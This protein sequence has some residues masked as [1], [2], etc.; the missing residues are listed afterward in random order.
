MHD[1]HTDKE[2][3][4]KYQFLNSK[5]YVLPFI[6]PFVDMKKTLQ[7]L[8]IGCGEAGVLKAFTELD[9]QC[10]GIELSQGRIDTARRFMA[11]EVKT[12]K[13]KFIAR[14]IYDIDVANDIGHKFDIVILKDVIEH[15]YDQSKFVHRLHEFL[16]DDG[17]VFFGFPPW[18]MPYGGHQQIATKKILT[19]PFYHI[20]PKSIYKAILKLFGERPGRIEDLMEIKD[21]AISIERFE[22]IIKKE[23]YQIAKRQLYLINPIYRY[24]FNLK[25]RKQFRLLA[26]IPFLRNFVTTCAFYVIKNHTNT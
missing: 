22:R 7:V 13:I 19:L 8:E 12:G 9:H 10:L 20:L 26:S 25:P 18:Y 21:T 24:K 23:N 5:E 2:V 14:N 11:E 17:V 6:A 1:F 4:F 3:Y 15:I 16:K